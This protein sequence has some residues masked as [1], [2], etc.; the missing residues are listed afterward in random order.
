[1][2]IPT[3]HA[4]GVF[5]ARGNLYWGDFGFPTPPGAILCLTLLRWIVPHSCVP[6]WFQFVLESAGPSAHGSTGI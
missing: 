2:Q 1:M 5:Y 4:A 3:I 6:T